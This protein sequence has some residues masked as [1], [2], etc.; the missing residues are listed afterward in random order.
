[1]LPSVSSKGKAEGAG[2]V[3]DTVK[4]QKDLDEGFQKTVTRA[5][6]KLQHNDAPEKPTMDVCAG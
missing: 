1:M 5:V 4:A 2:V 6:T 3:E